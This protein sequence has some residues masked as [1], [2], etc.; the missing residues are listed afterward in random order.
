[1][2]EDRGST[3]LGDIE[4]ATLTVP[5]G[6]PVQVL[7]AGDGTSIPCPCSNGSFGNGCPNSLFAGGANLAAT[8]HSSVSSD[9][10]VLHG[11]QMPNATAVYF[12]GTSF[13]SPF[14]ID[15]GIM[16]TGGTIIRLGSK[17]NAGNASQYPS[18]GDAS[19]SVRGAIPS[20]AGETRMYQAFYRNAAAF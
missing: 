13:T 18:T 6:G 20:A 9:S 3:T 4:A 2:W 12:Q 17:L 16:C 10:L 8:G 11:S 5:N 14:V 1:T 19:I 15:D 7:C